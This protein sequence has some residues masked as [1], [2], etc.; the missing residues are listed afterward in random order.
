MKYIIKKKIFVS[1]GIIFKFLYFLKIYLKSS[2]LIQT[3]TYKYHP[4]DITYAAIII[5]YYHVHYMGRSRLLLLLLY[6]I[7]YDNNIIIIPY[8]ISHITIVR[9]RGRKRIIHV[10]LV[11]ETV[12]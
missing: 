4:L 8:S 6:Y 2:I 12:L 5:M 9:G 7:V 11:H 1:G 10:S 3:L